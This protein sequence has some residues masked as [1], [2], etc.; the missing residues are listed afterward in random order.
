MIDIKKKLERESLLDILKKL[1]LIN[2]QVEEGMEVRETE[3]E[4]YRERK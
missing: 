2:I 3:R 1:D 4:I